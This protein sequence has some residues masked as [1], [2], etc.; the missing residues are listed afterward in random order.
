MCLDEAEH[1]HVAALSSKFE[2]P[3]TSSM[4]C[5]HDMNL[6]NGQELARSY[7]NVM[8]VKPVVEASIVEPVVP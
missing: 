4:T 8:L 3:N 7:V 5:H 6:L 1:T 2:C